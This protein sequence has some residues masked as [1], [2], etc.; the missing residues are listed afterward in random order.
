MDAC[1][2]VEDSFKPNLDCAAINVYLSIQ[3]RIQM[4]GGEGV[5]MGGSGRVTGCML[6]L[7]QLLL[8]QL[9]DAAI[10]QPSVSF[11]NLLRP[12]WNVYL[13]L[14]ENTC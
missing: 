4:C 3:N 9:M 6:S 14:V 13:L 12:H 5:W 8:P 2:T 7:C 1:N 10:T 11:V